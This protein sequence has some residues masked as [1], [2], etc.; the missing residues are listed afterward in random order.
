MN[1]QADYSQLEL[2][3]PQQK[4]FGRANA[5]ANGKFIFRQIKNHEK[6]I[7]LIVAIVITGIVSFS[8][9]VE[10]GRGVVQT[11]TPVPAQTKSETAA[12]IPETGA[13]ARVEKKENINPV[14]MREAL[15][16]YTIQLASYLSKNSA[17]KEAELL[18]K[19]G[20]LPLVV[21]KGKYTVICVGN[22]PDKK[23]ALALLPELK[24]KYRDCFI[25]RL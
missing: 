1:E 19:K 13:E 2:F 24:K 16:Y 25:R 12:V 14:N 5:S 9:G 22:F 4:L 21:N 17:Q 15:R 3:S 6:V 7:L 10:K 20:L 23:N 11:K 18:K 8:L